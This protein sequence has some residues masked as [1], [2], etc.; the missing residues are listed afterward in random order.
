MRFIRTALRCSDMQHS[1]RRQQQSF[2]FEIAGSVLLGTNICAR[3][4]KISRLLYRISYLLRFHTF[5]R[6]GIYLRS[7]ISWQ[8]EIYHWWMDISY[9][10]SGRR[11]LWL[12][13][14][15]LCFRYT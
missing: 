14:E 5:R 2:T 1:M 11:S 10:R 3:G 15:F 4:A 7:K 12:G 8:R 6:K 13:S 9:V